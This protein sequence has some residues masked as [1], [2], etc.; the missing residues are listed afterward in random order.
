[1]SEITEYFKRHGC[2]DPP[3]AERKFIETT[4]HLQLLRG[5]C[6]LHLAV[7]PL[8]GRCSGCKMNAGELDYKI[9]ILGGRRPGQNPYGGKLY[10]GSLK[11]LCC[12]VNTELQWS[13]DES[14]G[15]LRLF[16]PQEA[17]VIFRGNV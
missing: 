1:M 14:S 2:Y 7:C 15:D 3:L 11:A 12:V 16:M 10:E 13:F 9:W 4:E 8:E 5:K 17:G 6:V